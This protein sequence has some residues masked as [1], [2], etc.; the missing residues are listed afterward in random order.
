MATV[1]YCLLGTVYFIMKN[2]VLLRKGNIDKPINIFSDW[3]VAGK[4]ADENVKSKHDIHYFLK[5]NWFKALLYKMWL[6]CA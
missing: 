5:V 4:W 6:N 2:I 3:Y 1:S